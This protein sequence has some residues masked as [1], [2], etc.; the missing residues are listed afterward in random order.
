MFMMNVGATQ[1]KEDRMLLK[2]AA[3]YTAIGN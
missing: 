2:A 1:E 3:N